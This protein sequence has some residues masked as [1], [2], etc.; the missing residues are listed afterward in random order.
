MEKWLLRVDK[1][2]HAFKNVIEEVL[3][4]FSIIATDPRLQYG[5]KSIDKR[6]APVEFV[7]IGVLLFVLRDESY[8]ARATG[9][10]SMRVNVRNQFADI[11]TNTKVGI[12]FWRFI[13]DVQSDPSPRG[14]QQHASGSS[15]QP[16]SGK[17]R[18]KGVDKDTESDEEYRPSPMKNLGQ[19]PKTRSKA[20]R[21][22]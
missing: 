12:A 7:F 14:T 15:S 13:N 8:E 9:I 1:P 19:T 6:L 20:P 5:F 17:K 4:A 18:R 22:S 10:Y 2:G 21:V 3:K 16:K 11:R